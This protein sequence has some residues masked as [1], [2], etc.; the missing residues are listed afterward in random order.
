MSPANQDRNQDQGVAPSVREGSLIARR[1]GR[2]GFCSHRVSTVLMTIE[3]S[4]ISTIQ[5]I[6][7]RCRS[8]VGKVTR[9]RFHAGKDEFGADDADE[10][11]GDGELRAG[12]EIRS[13]DKA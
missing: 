1:A 11:M 2:G 9:S 12:E 4:R 6:H 7:R 13:W 3:A 8:T 5:R 10:G